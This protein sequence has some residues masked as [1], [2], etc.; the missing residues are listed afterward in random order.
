[1]T[2]RVGWADHWAG[3]QVVLL[4]MGCLQLWLLLLRSALKGCGVSAG[5]VVGL[6]C[7]RR[8]ADRLRVIGAKE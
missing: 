1:M 7:K 2:Y 5:R 4:G 8:L 6:A 3:Q